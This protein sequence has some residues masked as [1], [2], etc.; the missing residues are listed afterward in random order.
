M[1]DGDVDTRIAAIDRQ[2]TRLGLVAL[3]FALGAVSLA[4]L[5]LAGAG[6]GRF[7]AFAL[8]AAG[9]LMIAMRMRLAWQRV[10]FAREAASAE[11]ARRL[12]DSDPH[13]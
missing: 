9:G 3:A 5:G 7:V 12:R 4:A 11:A 8:L 2:R 13:S 1:S 6:V 10:Q